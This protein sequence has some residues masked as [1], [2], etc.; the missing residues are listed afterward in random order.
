[1]AETP[2]IEEVVEEPEVKV[3]EVDDDEAAPALVE[4]AGDGEEG[5]AAPG[6]HRGKQSRSEKKTRKQIQKLGMKPVNDVVR[7]TVK[8]G[9]QVLFVVSHPDVFKSPNSDTYVVFG[10]AKMDDSPTAGLGNAAAAMPGLDDGDMPALD[11]EVPGLEEE[12]P[13]AQDG[14][15]AAEGGVTEKDIELVVTQAK[16]TREKAIEVLKKTNGD[17]VNAIM[18]LTV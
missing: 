7:M 11:E 5:D 14:E 9:K 2:K 15:A 16:C 1:M 3:E 8:K 13:A 18:E 12:T 17:I 4:E 6:V 10:E